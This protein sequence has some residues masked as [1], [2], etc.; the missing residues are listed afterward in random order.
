[1]A[2]FLLILKIAVI[3]PLNALI[4][5]YYFQADFQSSWLVQLWVYTI[6]HHLL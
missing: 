6:A 3:Q 1:M 4:E 5:M 2:L